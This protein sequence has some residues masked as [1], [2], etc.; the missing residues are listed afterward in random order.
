MDFN[1]SMD[2]LTFSLLGIIAGCLSLLASRHVFLNYFIDI[3]HI[4]MET[5]IWVYL[6]SCILFAF[7]LFRMAY[8]LV[9]RNTD[10]TE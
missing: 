6:G 10:K 5:G 4:M 8:R 9:M 3:E 1:R 2:L 7:A